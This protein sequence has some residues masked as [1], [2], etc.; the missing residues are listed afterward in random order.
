MFSRSCLVVAHPDD[1]ILWFS[2]ILSRV[3]RVILCFLANPAVPDR[4]PARRRVLDRYPMNHIEC[5][6][7][8]VPLTQQCGDWSNPTVSEFGLQM[9]EAARGRYEHSFSVLQTRLRKELSGCENV[10]THNPWG[11]YGH[12]MHVQVHRVIQSLSGEVGY[13]Q[14]FSNYVSARTSAFAERFM[15]GPYPE[16]VCFATEID[17]AHRVRELYIA[18]G[19]WTVPM[20]YVW[21]ETECYNRL[22]DSEERA[23]NPERRVFPLNH[24]SWAQPRPLLSLPQRILARGNRLL[25]AWARGSA[26]R[27]P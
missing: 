16:P 13:R 12:E 22:P 18:E 10:I 5:L 6:E 1:E 8:D 15:L 25:R 20:D 2:S 23:S 27:S 4:G 7:L 26:R 14:W 17:L 11:E 21:C 24:V 3:D 19:C 9:P